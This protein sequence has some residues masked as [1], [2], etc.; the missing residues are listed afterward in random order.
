VMSVPYAPSR[1][2]GRGSALALRFLIAPG[3]GAGCAD[4]DQEI[5][6][7]RVIAEVSPT[8]VSGVAEKVAGC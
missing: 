6:V 7:G 3:S 2:P 8:L 1:K 5:A 4:R